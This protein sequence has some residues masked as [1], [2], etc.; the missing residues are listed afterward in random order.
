MATF[1]YVDADIICHRAIASSTIEDFDLNKVDRMSSRQAMDYI[2]QQWTKP[3]GSCVVVPVL[4][5]PQYNFRYAVGAEYKSN[6][7]GGA[8]P[9]IDIVEELQYARRYVTKKWKHTI[10]CSGMGIEA[11]DMIGILVT[12]KSGDRRIGVSIDKDFYTI[13]GL[14]LNPT[15]QRRP[16]KVSKARAD[17]MWM[18]QTLTGDTVD[19]YKG[20]PGVGPKTAERILDGSNDL[21]TM[22]GRVV[23]AYMEKGMDEEEALKN[24]RFARILRD[25]D[26]NKDTGSVWLFTGAKERQELVFDAETWKRPERESSD[27]TPSDD[28]GTS[29]DAGQKHSALQS[30]GKSR[31]RGRAGGRRSKRTSGQLDGASG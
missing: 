18:L 13:P 10:D 12:Q 2:I 27:G 5:D 4:S 16:M 22:W 9:P 21:A 24:A 31:P 15:K 20:I 17:W 14:I 8:G 28:A 26:Y 25:G 7:S 23:R 30:D 29:G 6:R 3:L 19:G 1:A 11:D